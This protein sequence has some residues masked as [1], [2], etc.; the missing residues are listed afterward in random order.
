MFLLGMLWDRLHDA[1]LHKEGAPWGAALVHGILPIGLIKEQ[2]AAWETQKQNN[3]P[4]TLPAGL[5][6]AREGK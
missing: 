6:K 4:A 2:G 3:V 5:V 1:V